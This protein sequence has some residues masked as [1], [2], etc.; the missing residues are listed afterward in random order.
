MIDIDRVKQDFFYYFCRISSYIRD[1]C[2]TDPSSNDIVQIMK[3]NEL[4]WSNEFQNKCYDIMNKTNSLDEYIKSLTKIIVSSNNLEQI[5]KLEIC[6]TKAIIH[7]IYEKDDLL[8]YFYQILLL[9]LPFKYTSDKNI[10]NLF[11]YIKINKLQSEL[12]ILIDLTKTI[13][14]NDSNN[15]YLYLKNKVLKIIKKVKI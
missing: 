9:D 6:I 8:V 3:K 7:N 10:K 5:F 15:D 14:S 13:I 12:L 2:I 11:D 1:N 4:E